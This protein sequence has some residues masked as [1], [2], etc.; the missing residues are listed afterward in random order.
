[1]IGLFSDEERAGTELFDLTGKVA[2]ITATKRAPLSSRAVLAL[3][4]SWRLS[5]SRF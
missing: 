3:V 1:L 5:R 4:R 2:L